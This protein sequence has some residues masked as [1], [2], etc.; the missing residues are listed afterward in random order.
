MQIALSF[1]QKQDFSE[2]NFLFLP[3][4]S[5]AVQ[6]LTK[7]FTQSNFAKASMPSL[8]LKGEK[9]CGKS[10]LLNIFAK[11]YSG[12]ILSKKQ[13]SDLNLLEFFQKNHFYIFEDVDEI[14]DDELLLHLVNSAFESGAFLVMS[15][16]DSKN[17]KLWDLTSRLKNIFVSSIEP[18]EESSIKPLVASGFAADKL[19]FQRQ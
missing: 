3:E 14:A 18:L 12:Q 13:I 1:P 5:S 8:I 2:E 7:F 6:I 10:H 17:F 9:A 19:S 4:N 11:K 16:K 15:L